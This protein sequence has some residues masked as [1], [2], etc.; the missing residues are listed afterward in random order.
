MQQLSDATLIRHK[1][2]IGHKWVD[3]DDGAVIE[4]LNPLDGAKLG[5]V[6][7]MGSAETIRAIDAAADAFP[8]WSGLIPN[9]RA[10]LLHAW[11]GEI[12]RHLDDLARILTLEQGKPF[13]EARGEVAMGASYIPWFAEEARRAYGAV[14]PVPRRG[15]QPITR[16][17]PLG[18]VAAITP[19]NFPSSMLARKAAAILAAG[20]T[21]VCKPASATP[22]SV[23]AL[24][25]LAKRA[26][27]PDGVINV[28]TGTPS[29]ISTAI[30]GDFRVRALTFTGSTAVGKE[31]MA[32]MA[33]TMKRL[34]MELGGNAPFL[35]FDDADL[36]KAVDVC[37]ASK[38]R[39]AG[40]TCICSNRILVQRGVHDAFVK[41]L[42]GKVSALKVG[43]GTE[44]G[45]QCGP[46]IDA[47]AARK[48]DAMVQDATGKGAKVLCGGTLLPDKG[49]G[50][51]A[52]TVIDG[53]TP[54]MR[55]FR[56]EIFG[57]IAPVMAFDTEKEAVR[58]ANDTEFGLASYVCTRDLGR[59][60]RVSAALEYGMVGVNDA[61]LAMPEV[62][63]G[64]IK[65]SGH[66]RE[67]GFEGLRDFM[68]TRYTLLGGL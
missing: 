51:F 30:G 68:E 42:V 21:L 47:D 20:C 7:R 10:R 63:F 34:C 6:P 43:G 58:L 37:M 61:V 29:A 62:P 36:E 3:A 15:V 33:P 40:Q 23:L 44:P 66:G 31:L 22:Y 59:S 55:V 11:H 27:I 24:A 18:V 14:I 19:W 54:D 16:L 32:A 12:Q 5:T 49:P 67:G 2:L 38:F 60:L 56:E 64:G 53:M 13:A 46:L 65:D 26:D 25:E 45:V 4:V 35:V 28:V 52:P 8:A 1:C 48:C 50:F 9:V 57:P 17:Q 41:G 39:N